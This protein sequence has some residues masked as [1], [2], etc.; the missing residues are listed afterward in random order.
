MMQW[1]SAEKFANN[2][3]NSLKSASQKQP[4]CAM[5]LDAIAIAKLVSLSEASKARRGNGATRRQRGHVRVS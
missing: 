4:L 3:G 1:I 5:N 2:P